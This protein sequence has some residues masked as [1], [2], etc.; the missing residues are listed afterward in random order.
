M[1]RQSKINWEEAKATWEADSR[2][3]FDWLATELGNVVSRQAISKKANKD[4]WCKGGDKVAQQNKQPAKEGCATKSKV[5][6]LKPNQVK[7]PA[8]ES[9]QVVNNDDDEWEEVEEVKRGRGQPTSYKPEYAE[10]AY[11]YCLLGATDERL[12]DFF[13]VAISTIYNWKNQNPDFLE[14]ID[15][16]KYIADSKVARSLYERA[17]GYSHRDVDI[18]CFQGEIIQTEIIKHYPPDVGAAK[19]ILYN[20]HPEQWK[21]KQEITNIHT[22]DKDLLDSIKDIRIERLA[23]ARERQR[24]VLIERGLIEG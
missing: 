2:V 3:G 6:Q 12:A 11:N 24:Q 23:K 15:N 17:L 21:D 19:M 20:R 22:V 7:K 14:A 4:G 9:C 13:K 10:Q 8:K 18:K 1:A 5:A 16:G